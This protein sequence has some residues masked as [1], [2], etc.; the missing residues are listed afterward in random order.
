MIAPSK[1]SLANLIPVKKGEV[2]NPK[3]NNG[4]S[5]D[6]YRAAN[7]ILALTTTEL[8]K[9]KPETVAELIEFKA[10]LAAIQADMAAHRELR[11]LTVGDRVNMNV[12]DRT[13]EVEFERENALA[14]LTGGS[15][16]HR[17]GTG[18]NGHRHNGA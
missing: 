1:K 2:R 17:N 6:M 13:F 15:D 4:G 10:A 11:Q 9:F 5:L 18:S 7:K 12:Q 14:D 16:G 3:G 8:K